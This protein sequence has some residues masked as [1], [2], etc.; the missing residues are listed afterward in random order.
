MPARNIDA[1]VYES[2]SVSHRPTPFV[3]PIAF[4]ESKVF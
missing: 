3:R 1:A 2:V 4:S